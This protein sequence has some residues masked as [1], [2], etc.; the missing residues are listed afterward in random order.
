MEALLQR[1]K[2]DLDELTRQKRR[3]EHRI[4][5]QMQR[6]QAVQQQFAEEACPYKVGDRVIVDDRE[7]VVRKVVFV[8]FAPFWRLVGKS[9][10]LPGTRILTAQNIQKQL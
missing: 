7:Y 4:E 3:L 9:K 6:M 10:G 2:N 1:M 5:E 8:P